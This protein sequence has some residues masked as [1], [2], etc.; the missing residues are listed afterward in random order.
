M[1]K[2]RKARMEVATATPQGAYEGETIRLDR[3][4]A[5]AN[6][7]PEWRHRGAFPW[8]TLWLIWPLISLAKWVVPAILGG[9]AAAA[10]ALSEVVASGIMFWPVLL[11]VIGVVLLRKR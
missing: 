11:I 10:G 7:S 1:C 6:A 5:D 3:R 4:Q 8:W 2:P 9:V